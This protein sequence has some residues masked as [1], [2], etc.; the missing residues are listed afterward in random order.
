MNMK[1]SR[2]M[3]RGLIARPDF[4]TLIY[5]YPVKITVSDWVEEAQQDTSA[6]MQLVELVNEY[7]NRNYPEGLLVKFSL[8]SPALITPSIFP[9]T[10]SQ[11]SL[12]THVTIKA[13]EQYPLYARTRGKRSMLDLV[14]AIDIA[15]FT[16]T[17]R[18]IREVTYCA[19]NTS[20]GAGW[21]EPPPNSIAN[22]QVSSTFTLR[23][24]QH[25][26]GSIEYITRT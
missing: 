8:C 21:Q 19:W 23:S 14:R 9:A 4:Q 2:L 6:L 1:V 11:V 13:S 22:R 10:P 26:D 16:G 20:S 24:D 3:D 5:A 25:G 17:I 7:E 15:G 18:R 12:L